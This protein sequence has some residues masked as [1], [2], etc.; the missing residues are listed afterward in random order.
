M[1][2]INE[3]TTLPVPFNLIPTPKTI[4]YLVIRIKNLFF[5]RNKTKHDSDSLSSVINIVS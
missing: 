5:K 1:E 2:F 4:F 3:K